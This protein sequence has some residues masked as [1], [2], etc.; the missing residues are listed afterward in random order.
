MHFPDDHTEDP[1]QLI[2][3]RW[4]L[5]PHGLYPRERRLWFE[6]LWSDVLMLRQRY[7]MPVRSGWWENEIPSRRLSR[8]RA[9]NTRNWLATRSS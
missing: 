6:Q 8:V 2:D 4:P 9:R 3:T 1:D 7:R 5:H